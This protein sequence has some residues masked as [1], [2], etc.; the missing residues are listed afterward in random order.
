MKQQILESM[1]LEVH[2]KVQELCEHD[3]EVT[4][5]ALT[6]L[7]NLK[8]Y[9]MMLKEDIQNGHRQGDERALQG[10]LEDHIGRGFKQV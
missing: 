3:K 2:D 9:T 8:G 7:Y 10:G 1:V 6:L 4:G 5:K